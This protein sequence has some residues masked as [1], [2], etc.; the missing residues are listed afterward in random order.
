M[1]DCQQHF[2][3]TF[4]N[5]SDLQYF[6]SPGIFKKKSRT[7]QAAWEPLVVK[8]AKQQPEGKQWICSQC[9]EQ[10]AC[11]YRFVTSHG[12]ASECPDVKNYKWLLNPVWHRMLYSCTH[13]A[14]VGFKGLIRAVIRAFRVALLSCPTVCSLLLL[15]LYTLSKTNEWINLGK[16]RLHYEPCD[17]DS[18]FEILLFYHQ[19]CGSGLTSPAVDCPVLY[20]VHCPVSYCLLLI[21]LWRGY[22]QRDHVPSPSEPPRSCQKHGIHRAAGDQAACRLCCDLLPLS[23]PI[24]RSA[25]TTECS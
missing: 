7:F 5:Q 19:L 15:S 11:W 22:Q 20:T 2:S 14:T 23:A 25:D 18:L 3:R 21:T 24:T 6:P 4:Q 16:Q 1:H 17:T 13:M 8:F 12:W 9:L 10:F